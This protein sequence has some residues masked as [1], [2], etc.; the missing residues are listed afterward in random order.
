MDMDNMNGDFGEGSDRQTDAAPVQP[1]ASVPLDTVAPVNSA[2]MEAVLAEPVS[3]T[4]PQVG[5]DQ[6]VLSQVAP[7]PN[8]KKTGLIIGIIAGILLIGGI[9]GG[10]FWYQN[11]TKVIADA[12]AKSASAK[13]VQAK[14]KIG[15]LNLSGAEGAGMGL[16][17][18]GVNIDMAVDLE[19][20]SLDYSMSA[21]L[22]LLGQSIPLKGKLM[23]VDKK[24]VYFYLEDVS[25]AVE[26]FL[27][28]FGVFLESMMELDM[29]EVKQELLPLVKKLENRWVKASLDELVS[30]DDSEGGN[31]ALVCMLDALSGIDVDKYAQQSKDLF[32]KNNYFKA[33]DVKSADGNF[34]IK[35]SID[36]A[37]LEAYNKTLLETDFV[38]SLTKCNKN[39]DASVDIDDE[40]ELTQLK[41]T[42]LV[43]S[44]WGHE[45]KAIRSDVS[46][47][48][49]TG[50][51]KT[52][53]SI[54]LDVEFSWPKRMDI[55]A[56]SDAI[57]SKVWLQEIE[58]QLENVGGA[59]PG[60]VTDFGSLLF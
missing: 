56:P 34:V 2:E 54:K 26:N 31:E 21:N 22:G 53:Q 7:K 44:R 30:S 55:K 23:I 29:A 59:T 57:D 16:S 1:D 4:P 42:E 50:S 48:A 14:I 32:R 10:Y 45:L 51:E 3:V 11:P 43:I 27:T 60:G 19:K 17:L 24:N 6:T 58:A 35:A 18:D 15:E 40:Q 20:T 41:N 8:G 28:G 5:L 36:Q 52:S 38:K 25:V 12:F 39:Q 46:T 47:T 37:K 9:V 33:G 49:T 13:M